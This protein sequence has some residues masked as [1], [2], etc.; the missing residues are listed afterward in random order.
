VLGATE[1][2]LP[3]LF[4]VVNSAP[5]PIDFSFPK[6]PEFKVWQQLLD[7]AVDRE[8]IEPFASGG[9]TTALPRSVLAYAGIAL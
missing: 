3:P 7:T 9:K 4:V 2:G 1:P 5:Q 8:V 6:L